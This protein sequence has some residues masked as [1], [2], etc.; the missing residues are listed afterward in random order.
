LNPA[1]SRRFNCEGHFFQ[2]K[3]EF[4][5]LWRPPGGTGPNA[6]LHGHPACRRPRL[7]V[8]ALYYMGTTSTTAA[9]TRRRQ[10]TSRPTERE[11][12]EALDRYRDSCSTTARGNEQPGPHHRPCESSSGYIYSMTGFAIPGHQLPFRAALAELLCI[13]QR[14]HLN[15]YLKF[16]CIAL[17]ARIWPD[18][19]QLIAAF[20]TGY[21]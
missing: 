4:L 13:N 18:I 17:T 21:I 15:A 8:A 20:R 2:V 16:P 3:Q 19:S 1:S 9:P 6:G 5:S 14:H 10:N 11:D 7:L 12:L